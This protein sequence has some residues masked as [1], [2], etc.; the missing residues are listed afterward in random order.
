[1]EKLTHF[2]SLLNFY[3]TSHCFHCFFLIYE[4]FKPHFPTSF[5]KI[6]NT[7]RLGCLAFWAFST[8]MKVSYF[9]ANSNST[10]TPPIYFIFS[11]R[12]FNFYYHISVRTRK[13]LRNTLLCHPNNSSSIGGPWSS[14]TNNTYARS[15]IR[16]CS[17]SVRIINKINS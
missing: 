17:R 4:N 6:T 13:Y 5:P 8:I 16:T 10:T 3:S 7:C 11:W 15:W 1:M 9:F 2:P 14:N 12:S